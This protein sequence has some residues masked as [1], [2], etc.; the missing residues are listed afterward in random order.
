MIWASTGRPGPAMLTGAKNYYD[1]LKA[2]HGDTTRHSLP[3]SHAG[4]DVELKLPKDP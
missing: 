1:G 2:P 3:G 4:Q